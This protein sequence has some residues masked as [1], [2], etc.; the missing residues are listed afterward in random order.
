[1]VNDYWHWEKYA[2]SKKHFRSKLKNSDY[3]VRI[4]A[5]IYKHASW[6]LWATF[7]GYNGD[8]SIVTVR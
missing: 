3:N 8:G 2:K 4:A 6:D 5:D 1:M 7:V